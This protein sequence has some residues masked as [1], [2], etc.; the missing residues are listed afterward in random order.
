MSQAVDRL[1]TPVSGAPTSE[2]E[3]ESFAEVRN[4]LSRDHAV[5]LDRLTDLGLRLAAVRAV[6]TELEEHATIRARQHLPSTVDIGGM[7]L[8]CASFIP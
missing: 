7:R 8:A 4:K 6:G 2:L 1:R 3:V 5:Q